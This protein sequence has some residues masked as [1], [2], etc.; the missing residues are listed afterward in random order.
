MY[1]ATPHIPVDKAGDP[2]SIHAKFKPQEPHRIDTNV[3]SK[4][5]KLGCGFA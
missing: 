5:R 2:G 1:S 3:I 4:L